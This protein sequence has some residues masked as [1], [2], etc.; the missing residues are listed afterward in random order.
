MGGAG[1]E[2]L[3][4]HVSVCDSITI[5]SL[6]PWPFIHKLIMT[7]TVINFPHGLIDV[8]PL[9]FLCPLCYV[10]VLNKQR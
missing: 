4:D 5:T 8:T 10:A 3:M 2:K 6:A 9:V 1:H 7:H